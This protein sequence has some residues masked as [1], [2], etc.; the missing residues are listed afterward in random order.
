MLLGLGDSYTSGGGKQSYPLVAA[1][2]LGWSGSNYAVG[3]SKMGAVAGQLAKTGS[4]LSNVT[5]VVLTTSGNDL[6]VKDAL[7]DVILKGGY[8]EVE[9]KIWALQPQLVSTYK[10]IQNAVRLGTKIFGIPYVDLISVGNKIPNENQAHQVMQVYSNMVKAAAAEANIGFIE[11]NT[12]SFIGHEM[13]SADPYCTSLTE[14]NPLHPNLRGD[15]K[16]GEVV[17]DYLKSL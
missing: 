11:A 2:L 8:K 13:Y 7:M 5:H 17:A 9:T 3:G 4:L 12:E 10:I 1:N 16:L 15:N 6:N 14:S